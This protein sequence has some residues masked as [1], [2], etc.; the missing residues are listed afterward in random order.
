VLDDLLDTLGL[1]KTEETRFIAYAR[2]K[3]KHFEPLDVYLE[4]L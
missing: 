3:N 1:E 2:L 4:K